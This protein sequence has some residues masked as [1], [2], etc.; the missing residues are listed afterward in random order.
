MV[1][2]ETVGDL[3]EAFLAIAWKY[4]SLGVQLPELC[5]DVVEFLEILVFTE[6]VLDLWG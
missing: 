1:N 5:L 6:F 4:R 3:I 2:K